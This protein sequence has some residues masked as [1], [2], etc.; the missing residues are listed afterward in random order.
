A[1]MLKSATDLVPTAPTVA[2]ALAALTSCDD[3][4][5]QLGSSAACDTACLRALCGTAITARWALAV[6]ASAQSGAVGQI[7]LTLS[8]P[9]IVDD[10]AAPSTFNGLW[11]GSLADGVMNV[12]IGGQAAGTAN[13]S[14]DPPPQ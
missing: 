11:K 3:F 7:E 2:S 4:A 1:A 9:A 12:S 5:V 14:I 13:P 8:A 10:I 6:D